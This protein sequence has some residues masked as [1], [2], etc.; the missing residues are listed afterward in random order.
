MELHLT[1]ASHQA[2]GSWG[3]LLAQDVMRAAGMQ[4]GIHFVRQHTLPTGSRPDFTCFLA[5]G[6]ALHLD[7]K[8]PVSDYRL[9]EQAET[10]EARESA[11]KQLLATMKR[12]I[13]A[14]VDRGYG[15]PATT[16]G[17]SVLFV[18]N[19]A[20]LSAVA[21]GNPDLIRHA[22]SQHVVVAD[23]Q[24]LMTVLLHWVLRRR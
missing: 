21:D 19:P 11:R 4:E 15:D 7:C 2:R 6:R 10:D 3:E 17:V 12:H 1:L 18:S 16:V 23:A 24:T 14:L 8:F 5:D 22:L 9:M 13:A 20:V